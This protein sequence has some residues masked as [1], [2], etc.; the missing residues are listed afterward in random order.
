MKKTNIHPNIRNLSVQIFVIVCISTLAAL[1]TKGTNQV[2][3]LDDFIYLGYSLD[4]QYLAPKF[5]HSYYGKR[6]AH[7][8]P[9]A[10]LF[11]L[12]GLHT[13]L[14]ALKVVQCSIVF[15][16]TYKALNLFQSNQISFLGALVFV[17]SPVLLRNLSSDHYDG[18][19]IVYLTLFTYFALK[20]YKN[21]VF[22]P[23]DGIA[24][25]LVFT[26]ILNGNPWAGFMALILCGV[27][28]T[29]TFLINAEIKQF[30]LLVTYF[31]IGA[32]LGTVCLITAWN[33]SAYYYLYDTCFPNGYLVDVYNIKAAIYLQTN[34]ASNWATRSLWRIL[35]GT[36]Y[37][38]FLFLP[39]G[40]LLVRALS[41]ITNKKQ[42]TNDHL[43]LALIYFLQ[44]LAYV[45]YETAA[46]SSVLGLYYYVG[47][48]YPMFFISLCCISFADID[49][50]HTKVK[51]AFFLVLGSLF[52]YWSDALSAIPS[53][54]QRLSVD[55]Y[56]TNNDAII[57]GLAFCL[58]AI[59]VIPSGLTLLRLLP[60]QVSD[61][62][63]YAVSATMFATC[64]FTFEFNNPGVF[65]QNSPPS[66]WQSEREHR[67]ASLELIRF[68]KSHV[69]PQEKVKFLYSTN[70][71]A[72]LDSIQSTFLW[73]VSAVGGGDYTVKSE[74]VD[75][76]R[77]QQV[78]KLVLLGAEAELKAAL[79][80]LN[81]LN[82]P[83][84][85]LEQRWFEYQTL[86]F[87]GVILN[88]SGWP[89][90]NVI[91]KPCSSLDPSS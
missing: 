9:Q 4:F 7:I 85:L 12:L 22:K 2:G 27:V 34:A 41:R 73:G 89:C 56:Y 6:I 32:V 70:G 52:A 25:G 18:S 17:L 16:A 47:Y 86:A 57:G 79:D 11:G 3:H 36:Y 39:F 13:G 38:Y 91:A 69:P 30:A 83:Y 15:G 62:T 35:D 58:V 37:F 90:N 49:T 71:S 60:K 78:T 65:D 59:A 31:L 23:I 76:L 63:L 67:S 50:N 46:N 45:V 8:F 21:K 81:K 5:G 66:A 51:L 55:F 42:A 24:A 10:F 40:A 43:V 80:S 1:L 84:D 33:C 75:L 88:F 64:L 28:T 68:V 74:T 48:L 26:L 19:T 53:I 77:N 44:L 54:A 20:I 72:N 87:S 61:K 82:S 29:T 14:L